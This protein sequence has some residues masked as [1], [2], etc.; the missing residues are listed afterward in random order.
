[1]T[2]KDASIDNEQVVGTINPRIEVNY[3][4]AAVC[5]TVVCSELTRSWEL[6]IVVLSANTM[7]ANL[8]IQWFDLRLVYET[9]IYNYQ[10]CFLI[11]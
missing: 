6:L 4:R 3:G 9:S 11:A 5:P 7:L 10:L 1:M 8:P 2:W